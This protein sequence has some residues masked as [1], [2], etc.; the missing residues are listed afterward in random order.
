M[1]RKLKL[2]KAGRVVIPKPLRERLRIVPGDALEVDGDEDHI[3]LRPVRAKARLVKELGIWVYQ[4]DGASD[5]SIPELIDRERE[6]R[7]KQISG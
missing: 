3:T 2:D 7:H 1:A 4:G 6:A 5:D